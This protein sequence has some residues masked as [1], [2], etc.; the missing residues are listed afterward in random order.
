MRGKLSRQP[1]EVGRYGVD[2]RRTDRYQNVA[3]NVCGCAGVRGK[4]G[5]TTTLNMVYSLHYDIVLTMPYTMPVCV[6]YALYVYN[7]WILCC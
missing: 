4:N 1:V 6:P 3:T 5:G 2:G 7:R